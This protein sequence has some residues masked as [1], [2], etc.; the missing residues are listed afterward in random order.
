MCE[1]RRQTATPST[2]S[3]ARLSSTLPD[4]TKDASIVEKD[5]T[6]ELYKLVESRLSMSIPANTTVGEIRDK[7]LRYALVAEFRSDL[8]CDPPPSLEMIPVPPSN[9][10]LKRIRR[11]C[12]EDAASPRE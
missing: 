6:T 3:R 1:S 5:A 2:Y 12:R 11:P 4:P 7:L 10:H 8:G 9:R